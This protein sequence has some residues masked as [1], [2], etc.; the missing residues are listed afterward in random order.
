MPNKQEK[1]NPQS[2]DERNRLI[3]ESMQRAY[4][5]VSGE[6]PDVKKVSVSP[7]GSNLLTG[8]MMPRQSFAVTNPFTGNITYDPDMMV[9]QSPTDMENTLAHE[10]THVRQTQNMPWYQHM[11]SIGQNMLGMDRGQTPAGLNQSSPL[12]NEYYWR[13]SE[14]EAFQTEKNR[15]LNQ[16][17]DVPDPMTG[18][19]DI[20]L[21][22]KRKEV[23][24]G[25][26]YAFGRKQ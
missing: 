16:G 5:K 12:N 3:D 25:P 6:M 13:P 26:R 19:R 10:L 8:L 1:P 11:M 24:T 23:D 20:I 17:L 14:M 2:K 22:S 9:G 4:T 7:R 21:P 15:T 18:S